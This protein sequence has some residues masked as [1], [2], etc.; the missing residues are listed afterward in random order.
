MDVQVEVKW[1]R[2]DAQAITYTLG[3]LSQRKTQSAFNIQTTYTP[4]CKLAKNVTHLDCI[5][6]Y[7]SQH[8]IFHLY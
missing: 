2:H 3:K 4:F 7:F 1:K 8:T 6:V 5:I